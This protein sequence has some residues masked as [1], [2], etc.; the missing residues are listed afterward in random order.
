MLTAKLLGQNVGISTTVPSEKLDVNGNINFSGAL[1]V[2]GNSG[3]QGD[4]LLTTVSGAEWAKLIYILKPSSYTSFNVAQNN[5]V[6]ID[7]NLNLNADYSGLN[8][9]RLSINGGTITGN[10]TAILS[11]GL[12]S[13]V[14]GTNFVNVDINANGV[15]FINCQFSGNIPRIGNSCKYVNCQ[16]NSLILGFNSQLGSVISSSLQNC[17]IP[18]ASEFTNSEIINCSIGNGAV[19]QNSVSIIS[20]CT[21][22]NVYIYAFQSDLTFA[23]NTCQNT[24]TLIGN[25]N[26]SPNYLTISNNLFKGIYSGESEVIQINPSSNYFKFYIISDNNFSLQSSTPRAIDVSVN[27]GN[28]FANSRVNVQNNTFWNCMTSLNYSSN[29]RISYIYNTIF[30]TGS[31]PPSSG[32]LVVNFSVVLF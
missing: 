23:K 13:V 15:T 2:N 16:F 8:S 7:G 28:P 5:Y 27:D 14:T 17:T 18:R 26:Q 6:K 1:K 32:N 19:N 12:Y 30:Q 21:L 10:G 3:Q 22:L 25:S 11:I 24:K 9:Q 4:A 20:E 29:L 31:H